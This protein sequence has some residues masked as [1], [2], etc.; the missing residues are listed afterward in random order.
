MSGIGIL[1][2]G[3]TLKPKAEREINDITGGDSMH[4]AWDAGQVYI[5]NEAQRG[6]TFMGIGGAVV[7]VGLAGVVVGAIQITKAKQNVA[8]VPS[9]GP[10]FTGLTVSGR[11]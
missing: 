4:E 3:S 5:S 7:A 8:L 2:A 6:R 9:V 1:I 11:F 10:V